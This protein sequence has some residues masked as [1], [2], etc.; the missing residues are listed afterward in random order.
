MHAYIHTY[1]H[2]I[3]PIYLSGFS[4]RK[5]I[6]EEL[7]RLYSLNGYSTRTV[8]C[9]KVIIIEWEI[10]ATENIHEFHVFIPFEDIF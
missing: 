8:A 2:T 6:V 7:C 9:T 4:V 5:Y 3:M 10:A 1:T